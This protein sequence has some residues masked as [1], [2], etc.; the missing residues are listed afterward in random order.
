MKITTSDQNLIILRQFQNQPKCLIFLL[1]VC[2]LFITPKR[3]HVVQV[4]FQNNSLQEW[5]THKMNI[6][7]ILG[8]YSDKNKLI[9]PLITYPNLSKLSPPRCNGAD[10]QRPQKHSFPVFTLYSKAHWPHVK[11]FQSWADKKRDWLT[12]HDSSLLIIVWIMDI[13]RPVS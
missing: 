10:K 2:V 5:F 1:Y 7:S 9:R 4:Y 8:P 12:G 11:S 13:W 6:L 3:I